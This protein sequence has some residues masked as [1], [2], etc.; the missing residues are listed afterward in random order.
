M[1]SPQTK[2][3]DFAHLFELFDQLASRRAR[4]QGSTSMAIEDLHSVPVPQDL[5][6]VFRNLVTLVDARNRSRRDKPTARGRRNTVST[7]T[8]LLDSDD[9]D[10]GVIEFPVGGKQYPFTFK[11]ML[12][13]LYELE[14]WGKKV[15]DVLAKSQND[16]RSLDEL[17]ESGPSGTTN[18]VEP[19]GPVK[20]EVRV[21][22]GLGMDVSSTK[23]TGAVKGRPRSHTVAGTGG[24][25]REAGTPTNLRP[26]VAQDDTPQVKAD[27]R[28]VKKRCIGRR[29]STAGAG[30]G[31]QADWFY[32]AIIASSGE[33][34]GRDAPRN[35]EHSERSCGRQEDGRPVV[36]R[37][38]FHSVAADSP[39]HVESRAGD[40]KIEE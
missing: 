23:K 35:F 15:K 27:A 7:T 22:F 6:P 12:H 8:A 16:F 34:E 24:R 39:W 31:D 9:D 19:T 26:T 20:G 18:K 4:S 17:R 37:R 28:P 5:E 10:D 36:V 32:D 2:S 21:R 25:V 13:K 30:S 29:K 3:S 40:D 33:F 38:R 14:E 11:M 1:S